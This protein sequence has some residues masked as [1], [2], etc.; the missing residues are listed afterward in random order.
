MR[1]YDG[2]IMNIVIVPAA[3][4]IKYHAYRRQ[5]SA[6]CGK[7]QGIIWNSRD[8]REQVNMWRARS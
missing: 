5:R 7:E 4:S 1:L 8:F 3:D 6:G 2:P